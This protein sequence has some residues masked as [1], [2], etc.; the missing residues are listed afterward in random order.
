MTRFEGL[1]PFSTRTTAA[2]RGASRKRDTKPELALRR[3][4]WRL[5][6]RYRLDARELPGRPDIVF[7]GAR[8]AV[9]CDGDFWHGRDLEARLAKLEGGHNAPYWT[10]KI[11]GNVARDRRN[12]EQLAAAG[13]HVMR[14]WESDIYES[15]PAIAQQ[16]RAAVGSRRQVRSRRSASRRLIRATRAS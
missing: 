2:A 16:I 13:W 1:R 4:L 6:L 14:F 11:A 3:E 7:A 10:A 5:G 15:A 9:F 8:I 12:E